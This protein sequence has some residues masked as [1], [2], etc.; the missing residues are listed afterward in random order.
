MSRLS[1]G[2]LAA[3]FA[4]VLGT[5]QASTA[6]AACSKA[7]LAGLWQY[8]V[9][10]YPPAPASI[11]AP[12]RDPYWHSCTFA[13]KPDGTINPQNSVCTDQAGKQTKVSGS[14]ENIGGSTCII[15]GSYQLGSLRVSLT[16]GAL[17]RGKDHIDGAG[18]SP[19][20]SIV[21]NATKL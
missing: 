7:D 12:I 16:R 5:G 18:S 1:W 17:S 4:L 11:F 2:R 3:A 10:T 13:I 8:Y 21:F 6:L 14:V 15:H 19:A 20:G 9:I